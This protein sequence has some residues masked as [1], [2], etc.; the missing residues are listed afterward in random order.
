M[1]MS[2]HNGGSASPPLLSGVPL[3]APAAASS[4][5]LPMYGHLLP[6]SSSSRSS[7]LRRSTKEPSLTSSLGKRTATDAFGRST[8]AGTSAA[9]G[10]PMSTDTAAMSRSWSAG[11]PVHPGHPSVFAPQQP[12]LVTSC[13]PAVGE[14]TCPPLQP[15]AFQHGGY[16][17]AASSPL[18]SRPTSSSMPACPPAL[19][20]PNHL[21]PGSGFSTLVD[22]FSPRYDPEHYKQLQEGRVELGYYALA[23]GQ[24]VGRYHTMHPVPQESHLGGFVDPFARYPSVPMHPA[25]P[26]SMS[27]ASSP[28]ARASRRYSPPFAFYPGQAVPTRT[29]P[30][31]A[32]SPLSTRPPSLATTHSSDHRRV[33]GESA[34]SPLGSTT[35]TPL[36]MYDPPAPAP[37]LQATTPLRA[38]APYELPPMYAGFA[39][40][41]AHLHPTQQAYSAYS[42]AGM[43]GVYWRG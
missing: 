2:S 42:N 11:M 39:P 15:F 34:S 17:S 24:G 22:S 13:N 36:S 10:L 12:S 25:Y 21:H 1:S 29:Q 43:P 32:L 9:L 23:A 14:W 8:S 37:F 18:Q 4:A 35:S 7:A 33:S 5:P 3:S 30:A 40:S 27:A 31:Y 41:L 20:L 38:M 6:N 16:V 26:V 28:I 19:A